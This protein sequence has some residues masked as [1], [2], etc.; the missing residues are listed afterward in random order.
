MNFHTFAVIFFFLF[1]LKCQ[2]PSSATNVSP[3]NT[4][5]A[6]TT[7]ATTTAITTTTTPT[8]TMVTTQIDNNVSTGS[9]SPVSNIIQESIDFC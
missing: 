7:I 2:L 4:S 5:E 9:V 8:T 1:L 6:T 3:D